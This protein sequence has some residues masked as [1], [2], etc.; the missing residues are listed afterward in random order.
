MD[1]ISEL[2]IIESL[3][4]EKNRSRVFK[5]GQGAGKSGSIFFF[6]HDNRFLIKT[7]QSG[8]KDILLDMLD[9]LI[10]HFKLT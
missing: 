8:E 7:L 2:D 5:A 4:P 9:D 3:N 10:S 6:S 1:N